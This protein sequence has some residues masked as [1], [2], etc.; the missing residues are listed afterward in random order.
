MEYIEEMD[1]EEL[2]KVNLDEQGVKR[3]CYGTGG[4]GTQNFLSINIFTTRGLNH[5]R[6]EGTLTGTTNHMKSDQTLSSYYDWFDFLTSQDEYPQPLPTCKPITVSR[7]ST[8]IKVGT[9]QNSRNR[10]SGV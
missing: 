5:V 2:D 10:E 7:T 8:D 6:G 4:I 1:F 3:K 9:C